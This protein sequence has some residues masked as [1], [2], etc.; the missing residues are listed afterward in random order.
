MRMKTP[1]RG[2]KM[3]SLVSTVSLL[4][5]W[6]HGWRWSGFKNIEL[7]NTSAAFLARRVIVAQAE[8]AISAGRPSQFPCC[9]VQQVCEVL[10]NC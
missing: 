3:I 8:A 9:A 5:V 4:G 7:P 2:A 1:S 10:A 6:N